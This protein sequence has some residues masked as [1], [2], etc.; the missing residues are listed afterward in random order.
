MFQIFR[1]Y[2]YF[3]LLVRQN[4]FLKEN[5]LGGF[6]YR[7]CF[8]LSVR[9]SAS[10]EEERSNKRYRDAL[11]GIT[12][13]TKGFLIFT[14]PLVSSSSKVWMPMHIWSSLLSF[15]KS[16][17]VSLCLS[18]SIQGNIQKSIQ[19]NL[20]KNEYLLIKDRDCTNIKYLFPLKVF[21]SKVSTFD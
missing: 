4:I 11:Q 5:E 7:E 20:K 15:K 6:K 10:H 12:L 13:C 1:Q 14:I 16:T 18:I 3:Q 9:K 17:K 21:I 19:I 2:D 8:C